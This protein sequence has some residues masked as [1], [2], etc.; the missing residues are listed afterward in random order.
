MVNNEFYLDT[1]VEIAL[2]LKM[3]VSYIKVKKYISWG[4]PKELNNFN[5]L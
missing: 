3:K 4:T 2:K 1:C 5:T